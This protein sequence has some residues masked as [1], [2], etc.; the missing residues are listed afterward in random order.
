MIQSTLPERN[1]PAMDRFTMPLPHP[2]QNQRVTLIRPGDS[3]VS[4]PL[5]VTYVGASRRGVVITGLLERGVYRVSGFAASPSL[6]ASA[7]PEKPAW[8][9]PLVV[10][11]NS[12]ESDLTPLDR[13]Q[14]DLLRENDNLTFVS[15]GEEISL[16]GEAIR[17]QNS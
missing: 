6:T 12:E 1:L 15:P 2:G 8:E 10:G 7:I 13:K 9:V 16:A 4:E 17:G 14:L 3:H 11:G 5:D